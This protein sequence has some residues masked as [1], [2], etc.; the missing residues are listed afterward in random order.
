[1]S[2]D[3]M[4]QASDG[5]SG[6]DGIAPEGAL[7]SG[8]GKME[9]DPRYWQLFRLNAALGHLT[10]I[11]HDD[12]DLGTCIL[13]A[14]TAIEDAK[15]HLP[16]RA[17]NEKITAMMADYQAVRSVQQARG[18]IEE[19]AASPRG[20]EVDAGNESASLTHIPSGAYWACESGGRPERRTPVTNEEWARE[21]M[22]SLP[23]GALR[24]YAE[25]GEGDELYAAI[26]FALSQ[27]Y[28]EGKR[29]ERK[30][31]SWAATIKNDIK[32]G[33]YGTSSI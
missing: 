28:E 8:P 19:Q 17:P 25:L 7:Q 9:D 21:I 16:G 32:V 6:E 12:A 1:M 22:N 10:I 30:R 31:A 27:A 33:G 5:N 26:S 24:R 14:M 13:D 23:A 18:Q 11:E 4:C 2:D 20:D 3:F 15:Q 29:D